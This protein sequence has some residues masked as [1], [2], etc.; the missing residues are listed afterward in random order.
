[1]VCSEKVESSWKRTHFLLFRT[2][3]EAWTQLKKS[4]HDE[5]EVHLKFSNKVKPAMGFYCETLA[6]GF[7]CQTPAT[8]FY[9]ETPVEGSYFET[10][11]VG[12]YCKSPG[13]VFYCERP[14]EGFYCEI[15]FLLSSLLGDAEP[16]HAALYRLT[17]HQLFVLSSHSSTLRWRNLCWRSEPTTSRR[18]WRSTTIT[19][20]TSESSWRVATQ[21]WRRYSSPS[22]FK[23][24]E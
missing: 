13:E 6:E 12:F 17:A 7:Y 20:P 15:P 23:S 18:T 9:C 21:A 16:H 11:G 5:A 24:L 22:C 8:G 14:A 1:M 3:G 4:L 10:S 2:L 19:S